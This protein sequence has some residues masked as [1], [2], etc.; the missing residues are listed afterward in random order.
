M[1]HNDLGAH[2]TSYESVKVRTSEDERGSGERVEGSRTHVR[3][4]VGLHTPLE[5]YRTQW[6]R[7]HESEGQSVHLSFSRIDGE[8]LE[9]RN[10]RG[11]IQ[12]PIRWL[13]G[14]GHDVGLQTGQAKNGSTDKNDCCGNSC[15]KRGKWDLV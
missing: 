6:G 1:G 2:Q 11:T 12:R 9:T 7:V 5:V 8:I 15:L 14:E 13:D 4:S 10:P 3:R